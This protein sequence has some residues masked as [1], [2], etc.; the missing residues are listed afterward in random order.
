MI[1]NY[2]LFKFNVFKS[3]SSLPENIL[4]II[5]KY[6]IYTK[7]IVPFDL[8]I[9]CI[10]DK[11]CFKLTEANYNNIYEIYNNMKCG[12]QDILKKS[13][14]C[15]TEYIYKIGNQFY[16][17][18]IDSKEYIRIDFAENIK[19]NIAFRW[20]MNNPYR[21]FDKN[22]MPEYNELCIY[23]DYK[24]NISDQLNEKC[25]IN[26]N[27]INNIIHT[28][29]IINNDSIK[30]NYTYL[31]LKTIPDIIETE[32]CFNLIYK[33]YKIIYTFNKL[34][35]NKHFIELLINFYMENN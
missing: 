7:C 10:C 18:F 27:D 29:K 6:T 3:V 17:L 32:E 12:R 34:F 5:K 35:S 23:L 33:K 21:I 2:M 15:N 4:Y 19:M 24:Y 16:K 30:L 20:S 25:V 1:D 11:K 8:L 31:Y 14:N 26:N 9:D 22:L 13:S 28:I